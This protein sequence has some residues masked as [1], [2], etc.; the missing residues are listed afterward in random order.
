MYL[1]SYFLEYLQ[2]L[3]F[4]EKYTQISSKNLSARTLTTNNAFEHRATMTT[5]T[6]LLNNSLTVT[7]AVALFKIFTQIGSISNLF[8]ANFTKFLKFQFQS[9]KSKT[10]IKLEHILAILRNYFLKNNRT[11]LENVL[12]DMTLNH[13]LSNPHLI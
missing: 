3:L 8:L 9:Q 7:Q 2:I 12:Y 11:I 5:A 13:L 1:C 4:V 6:F 10:S